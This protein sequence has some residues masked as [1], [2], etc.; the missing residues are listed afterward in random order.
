MGN[1]LQLESSRIGNPELSPAPAPASV[2]RGL[3]MA[4]WTKQPQVL[5]RVVQVVAIDVVE[6]QW[7]GESVPFGPS[8]RL[9]AMRENVLP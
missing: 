2:C 1:L 4:I 7:N 6:F 8:A 5:E 3:R 9:A